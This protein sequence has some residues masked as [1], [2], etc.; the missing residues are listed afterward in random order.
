[1]EREELMRLALHRFRRADSM[2][3]RCLER[4]V[5]HTGVYPTQHR[6]LMALGHEPGISQV[7]LAEKFEVS[8]AAITGSLKKLEKGGYITRDV[9]REDNRSNQVSVTEKGRL[10]IE[11]SI[12]MFHE[13]DQRFFRGFSDEEVCRFL[14]YMERICE[15]VT[16]ENGKTEYEKTDKEG[17]IKE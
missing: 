3:R 16:E 10:V 8:G 7:E 11:E 13:T 12:E 15:N 17:E 9:N 2:L 4:K 5:S 14:E 1:M 6:I